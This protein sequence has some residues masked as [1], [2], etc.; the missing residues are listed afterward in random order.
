[1]CY[2]L[3]LFHQSAYHLYSKLHWLEGFHLY[4]YTHMW[5]YRLHLLHCDWDNWQSHLAFLKWNEAIY[6]FTVTLYR[7]KVKSN[8]QLKNKKWR[9]SKQMQF[10]AKNQVSKYSLKTSYD[11]THALMRFQ[12]LSANILTYIIWIFNWKCTLYTS[13]NINIWT[14]ARFQL[15]VSVNYEYHKLLKPIRIEHFIS[16]CI[17]VSYT[18]I[19]C[20]QQ[21][22]TF[23]QWMDIGE[24]SV[25]SILYML[26]I[27]TYRNKEFWS[28]FQVPQETASGI[29]KPGHEL[30][31]Y[32]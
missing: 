27:Y 21:S 18:C 11:S 10:Y 7:V 6:W 4:L 16:L 13:L 17:L 25:E 12:W 23:Q 14:A 3:F 15:P 32:G 30:H 22:F 28:N 19:I 9:K 26:P 24:H 1:M 20:S 8:T 2:F 29:K 5:S 31:R